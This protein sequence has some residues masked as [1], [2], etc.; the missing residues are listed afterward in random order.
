MGLGVR[1]GFGLVAFLSTTTLLAQEVPSPDPALRARIR[2]A[3]T[4]WRSAT[5][6]SERAAVRAKYGPYEPDF[7]KFLTGWGENYQKGGDL[8][9]AMERF[10][11]CARE[12]DLSGDNFHSSICWQ[13]IAGTERLQ[14]KYQ[15]ALAH[16]QIAI[17]YARK[18]GGEKRLP[19]VMNNLA[20]IY[21]S[22]GLYGDGI[23]TLYQT[24]EYNRQAG[25]RDDPAPYQNLAIAYALRGDNARSLTNFMTALDLYEEKG[26]TKKLGLTHYNIGVLQMR[27]AN[28]EAAAHEF[29]LSL[30][31]SEK[32]GDKTQLALTLGDY[33]RVRDLQGHSKEALETIR[34]AVALAREQGYRPAYIDG[35]SNLGNFYL[36]HNDLARAADA[37]EEMRQVAA[38]EVGDRNSVGISLR[39]LA[40]VAYKR[41]DWP[42]VLKLTAESL[43]VSEELG[44][45]TGEWQA[46]AL[47]G[48]GLRASG[49]IAE[50]RAAFERAISRVERQRGMVAGGDVEQQRFFEKAVYPYREL[51]SLE[52]QAG[53]G[54]AG[55][56]AAERA[57]ARV[58]LD[59]LSGNPQEVDR[60]MT[61]NEREEES[62]LKSALAV[63]NARLARANPGTAPQISKDRDAAFQEYEAFL[64]HLYSVH[65]ELKKLRGGSPAATEADLAALVATPGSAIVEFLCSEDELLEFVVTAGRDPRKPHIAVHRIAIS[66]ADIATRTEKYRAMLESR[67][68]A[69]RAESRALYSL[70][71]GPAGAEL[72]G[73]RRVRLIPDG[74]LWML[75]FQ[76]LT[77]ETGRYWIE[78]TTVA[79]AH[80]ITFLRDQKAVRSKPDLAAKS[81]VL[82]LGDPARQDSE[83]IPLLADQTRR[84]A[85]LYATGRPVALT[86][87]E[88]TEAAFRSAAGGARIV[89][90]AAH[91]VV[92]PVNGLHSR[93]LLASRR[94]SGASGDTSDDGWL[95]AWELMRM[96]LDADLVVLSACETGRGK[97]ADG[98][99]L[100]GLTWAV[101]VSGARSAVV[102]QWRVESAST[103]DLMV[104]LHERLRKGVP[105]DE[106]LRGSVLALM[107]NP[108]YRHPMYWA[109]FIYSG[110]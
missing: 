27:Q 92:D 103:T 48:M 8:A 58:L 86:G 84:I 56:R 21:T 59:V 35:L 38:D 12:S 80:S 9:G 99:G 33:G 110:R 29:D 74:P 95:E 89:H 77:D 17:A 97:A 60:Y 93:I 91:G 18:P 37:F 76:A 24:L 25:I 100:L 105:G 40:F 14:G 13:L 42:G 20:G 78:N 63:A 66:R 102:S 5:N 65:P 11:F 7:H 61:P 75:P 26:E 73:K 31:F 34:K 36:M 43:K 107:Q 45:L 98:E 52:V 108:N 90:V 39:G 53:D 55:L 4:A 3:F 67:D 85:A 70:L 71:L 44:D 50:A 1:V 46:S 10:Q 51:A 22:M 16:Y 6:D 54:L 69:F 104:G 68:P 57:R 81:D 41:G 23:D 96:K 101:F 72:K 30:G 82:L 2:D 64:Q 49:R 62:R 28:Y 88:A 83:A 15:D 32:A 19:L 87:A 94:D 47:Q 106:A 79:W 109:P